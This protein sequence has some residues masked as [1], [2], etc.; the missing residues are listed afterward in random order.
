MKDGDLLSYLGMQVQ[1]M[2]DGSI[3]VNQPG[4]AEQIC[5]MFLPVKRAIVNTPRVANELTQ[6]G[7]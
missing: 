3:L 5:N 2:A 6:E 4:Y 1:V 7:D